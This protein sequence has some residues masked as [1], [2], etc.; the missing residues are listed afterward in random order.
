MAERYVF[1][2]FVLAEKGKNEVVEE[3]EE[4]LLLLVLVDL[5]VE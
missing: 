2:F 1:L 4:E 5:R 3:E